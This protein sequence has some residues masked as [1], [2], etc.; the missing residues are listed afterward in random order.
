MSNQTND[1]VQ[2]YVE[3]KMSTYEIAK[4]LN[5]YPNKIRRL[6]IKQNISLNDKSTAQK[7]AIKKGV[8]TIPTKG[9]KRSKEEKLKIS[10]SLKKYWDNISQEDYD[11]RVAFAKRKWSEMSEEEKNMMKDKAIQAIRKAG[12]EGSKLEKFLSTEITKAGYKVRTHE[13]NLVPNENL[14]IDMYFPDLKCILEVDGPSHFLPIWGEEKLKK[15]IKADSHKTGLILS[16]GYAIIRVRHASDTLSLGSKEELKNKIID[17]L[18]SIKKKFP[19]QSSR[20][21]E[22]DI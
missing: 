12:K 11:K 8:S 4:K 6:L 15:Q 7:N 13:K 18:A 19:K 20:Y 21:I 9:R 22:I 1:I 16:K 3:Q 2:M 10:H 14:E 17:Q 5:T